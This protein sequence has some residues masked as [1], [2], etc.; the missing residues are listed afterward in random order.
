[1]THQAL[2]AFEASAAAYRGAALGVA[3]TYFYYGTARAVSD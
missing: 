1:M 2:S 3:F